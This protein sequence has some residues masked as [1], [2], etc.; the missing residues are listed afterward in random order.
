MR[1]VPLWP[2]IGQSLKKQLYKVKGSEIFSSKSFV[3]CYFLKTPLLDTTQFGFTVAIYLLSQ[4]QF[5]NTLMQSKG[6]TEFS[7]VTN[8][9]LKEMFSM[10]FLLILL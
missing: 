8:T 2:T 7:F 4:D 1:N 3:F 10:Y 9:G 5:T 6:S